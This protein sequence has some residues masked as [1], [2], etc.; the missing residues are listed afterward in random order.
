MVTMQDYIL[1]ERQN[2]DLCDKNLTLKC[3]RTNENIVKNV[4]KRLPSF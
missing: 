3:R 4:Y 2:K 1:Y